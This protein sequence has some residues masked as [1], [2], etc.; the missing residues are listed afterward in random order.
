MNCHE[1]RVREV[2]APGGLA[3]MP[4]CECGWHGGLTR[5]RARA[6]AQH[7]KHVKR[8]QRIATATHDQE[9]EQ[10]QK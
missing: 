6:V 7:A 3:L 4:R 1:F 5:D 10:E 2:R 8:L 9:Q